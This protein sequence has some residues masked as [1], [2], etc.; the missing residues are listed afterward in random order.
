[1]T[2]DAVAAA[3]W[4]VTHVGAT[5]FPVWG[6]A[7]GRCLCGDPHDGTG[8]AGGPDN[9]G[10]HPATGKGGFHN[11]TGE[12]E[13]I[14]TFLANPGT[15]NYGINCPPGVF[16]VDVD[17][18]VDLLRWE[19]LQL[20]HGPLPA[21]L[22]TTTAHGRHYFYRWPPDV[23]P[24]PTGKLFGYVVRRHDDGYVIGPGSIHPTGVQYDT[25]RQE[26]GM[27]Y[28]VALLPFGWAKAMLEGAK[29]RSAATIT[30]GGELPA[31]GHRHDWLRDTARLYAGTVRDPDALKAAVMA[32]NAKLDEPK[33]EAEVDKAIGDVLVRFGPDAGRLLDA[34]VAET[35]TID[36]AD[37]LAMHL[38]LLHWAIPDLVPEGTTVIAAPPKV[39]KSCLVYQMAVEVALGGDLLGRDVEQGSVLYLALED[40]PRRGQERLRAALAGRSL[41]KGHLQV[42]WASRKIGAGLEEDIAQ[43]LDAHPAARMVA[44]DTLQKVRAPSSGR[45][46]AY[47]VDVEDLGRLQNLFRDRSIALLIVHHARK[48]GTGDD[49][50]ASVSG[51]YGITGSADTIMVIKRKRMETFGSIYVTGREVKDIEVSARFD[52]LLWH[53]APASL[54]ESSFERQEVY[55]IIRTEGPIFPAAIAERV[56]LSRTSVQ[57]MVTK[58]V[59]RGAVART[60]G[61]YVTAGVGIGLE[62]SSESSVVLRTDDSPNTHKTRKTPE[63][64]P[65]DSDDSVHG[66]VLGRES[67]VGYDSDDSDD[68][69]G[70]GEP[71]LDIESSESSETHARKPRGTGEW[72]NPCREYQSHRS[73]HRRTA[74]GWTCDACYPEGG[75]A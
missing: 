3:V 14:R 47:E 52:D 29:P 42:Q 38:P 35:A 12:L 23:G 71:I 1:M 72:E 20:Q 10:K 15:P 69:V 2:V 46:G 75:D 73:Q 51:T 21:T 44:I 55:D 63:S 37:L 39:G 49:F 27:P 54:A 67:S 61:G 65:D 62:E 68:S 50:L 26:S 32:A 30:V 45:R 8:K 74:D 70:A 59:E 41:P 40:G 56:G 33:S 24:M 53:E 16:S 22:T 5:V 34:P 9:I 57:N 36:G 66:V 58:L 64:L 7:A 11:A 6:S 28:E 48:E 19:D 17:G 43:W 18:A 31:K 13:R 60:T 25:L 4:F